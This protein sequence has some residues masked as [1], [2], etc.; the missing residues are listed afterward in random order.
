M[1]RALGARAGRSLRQLSGAVLGSL[2]AS[3][4]NDP[5]VVYADRPADPGTE[6]SVSDSIPEVPAP[7]EEVVE[8]N[9]TT[10]D[11]E[12]DPNATAA[13]GAPPVSE[14][15]HPASAEGP[16]DPGELPVTPVPVPSAEGGAGGGPAEAEPGGS[17]GPV[18]TPPAEPPRGSAEDP[19]AT[20]GTAPPEEPIVTAPEQPTDVDPGVPNGESEGPGTETPL[21]PDEDGPI[22][23][24]GNGSGVI[25][26][27]GGAAPFKLA[28]I[29]SSTA[30]GFGASNDESSWVARLESSLVA[31]VTAGVSVSNLAVGGYS[32]YDLM[33][34]SGASG[35]IDVA[36]LERP[37]L[38]L[39]GLAGSNDLVADITSTI[40]ID[41]LT[42]LR[43]TARAAGIP[44]FFVGT[45]PK[46]MSTADR[47][48]LALWNDQMA[49]NFSA[50]WISDA[51]PA[52]SPCFI[53]V[54]D[55]LADASLGIAVA[56]DSGDGHPNDAGH[57][58]L[59]DSADKIIKPYVCTRTQCR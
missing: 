53:D 47:E 3:A 41:Q 35:S 24:P 1:A 31:A 57:G 30:A 52:Y 59:F 26:V 50:C 21:D 9:E 48:L 51:T 36:I 38:I 54:F 56:L 2:L 40:F 22:E 13:E 43:D 6:Q 44:T 25:E 42:T 11:L 10:P 55:Q 32:G 8:A 5:G 19:D 27:P 45:L 34:G 16:A 17:A 23:G 18:V 37:D 15:T 12:G 39:V 49:V 28:V 58:I 20:E 33:P 14:P 7:A 46:N 29:G 4:C